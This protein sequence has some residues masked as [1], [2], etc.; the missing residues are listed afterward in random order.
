MNFSKIPGGSRGISKS[1]RSA[2]WTIGMGYLFFTGNWWPGILYLVGISTLVEVA[3][4]LIFAATASGEE[5]DGDEF[6]APMPVDELE[7][8]E[9]IPDP[10]PSPN[11]TRMQRLDP[12]PVSSAKNLS[13][14]YRT[15]LLPP[16][17]PNCGAPIGEKDVEMVGIK[18]AKCS[19]CGS[20]FS[21]SE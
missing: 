14:E 17:C 20:N 4:K 7:L 6:E 9:L 3:L 12:T 15:D 13:R 5:I 8:E 18:T 11:N 2:V 21:V 1:I 16:N 19:F 10:I